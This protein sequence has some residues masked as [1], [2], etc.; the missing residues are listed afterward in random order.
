MLTELIEETTPNGFAQPIRGTEGAPI[1]GPSNHQREA[2]SPGR[3]T[4]PVTDHGSVP[5]LKWTFA[6]SHNKLEEGGWARQTT[7]R[8]MSVAVELACVNMRLEAGVIREM[9]W[10]KPAEWGFMIKGNARVTCVDEEGK[11][12]QADCT[13]GD[14]WNFPSGIPHSIQGLAG[15]GCEFL[16]VFDDGAFNEEETFL[17]TDFLAHI[18]K[19]VLA[20]NFGVQESAF[21][22]IP[23]AE[24]YIF[25]ADIPGPLSKDRVV[26]AGPTPVI[27]THK[28]SSQEPIKSNNGSVRVTDSTNFPAA[29]TIAAAL[30]EVEPGGMRELHWHRTSDELQYFLEG[31]GRMT[32]YM[33][34]TNAGTFDYQA[35]DVGYVPRVTPHYVE[36]T[37]TT[38]LR[39]LEVW[40]TDKFSDLSLAQ[41]LAF[42]PYELVRAHLQI[43][44]SVLDR[45]STTK[46]PVVGPR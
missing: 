28:M 10:H 40:K 18:P 24:K 23:K 21:A 42:T 1:L 16:L 8:E 15:E 29:S 46:T 6:D 33:S 39:Y 30:V 12:Y 25:R 4:P 38:T 31:Q 35:G 5:N 14:I 36:N 34:N 3:L 17:V 7:I 45:V 43:E 9:H 41:W 37:G 44:K 11:T 27:Y 13:E 32:V 20:K 2:Q 26:G 19:S 22:N